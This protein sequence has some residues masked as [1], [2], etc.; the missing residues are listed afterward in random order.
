[1]PEK[2][3]ANIGAVI[4]VAVPLI[5]GIMWLASID[6]RI[7]LMENKD[8]SV[9]NTR[10]GNVEADVDD[11]KDMIDELDDNQQDIQIRNAEKDT[12]W[13]QQDTKNDEVVRDREVRFRQ[14]RRLIAVA[15]HPPPPPAN[16]TEPLPSSARPREILSSILPIGDLPTLPSPGNAL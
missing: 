13:V 10:L 12:K 9:V 14:N 15:S 11:N 2:F 5:A 16:E 6:N 7:V 1:M 3:I 4:G 8:D